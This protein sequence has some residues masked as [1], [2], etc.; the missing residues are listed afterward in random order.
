MTPE[1]RIAELEAENAT[2][3]Q[4]V[5]QLAAQVQE[6]HAR[7]AKDSHNSGKPPSTMGGGANRRAC[8]RRAA[9]S[10]AGNWATAARRCIW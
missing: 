10:P 6:L 9:R 5:E 2:L 8:A 3:R 1:A 7:L 4:Q